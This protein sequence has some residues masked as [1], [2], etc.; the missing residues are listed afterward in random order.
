MMNYGRIE[1]KLN[2]YLK[3]NN[4]S[5]SYLSRNGELRYDTILSYCRGE[6]TRLG[7]DAL[8]KLCS[9]LSCASFFHLSKSFFNYLFSLFLYTVITFC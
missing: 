4:I 2:K 3:D 5:R 7:T 6:V 9:T 8:A 1:I